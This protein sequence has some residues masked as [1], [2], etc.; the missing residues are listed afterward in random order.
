M[1]IGLEPVYPNSPPKSPKKLVSVHKLFSHTVLIKYLSK[2]VSFLISRM[3]YKFINHQKESR[4]DIELNVTYLVGG[5]KQ[6][7]G[8]IV[9]NVYLGLDGPLRRP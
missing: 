9:S 3:L 7:N 5:Q 4:P 8:E 2:C 1:K 6:L